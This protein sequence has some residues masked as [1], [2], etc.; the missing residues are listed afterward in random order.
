VTGELAPWRDFC[1]SFSRVAPKVLRVSSQN[2]NAVGL[3]DAIKAAAKQYMQE[4]RPFIARDGFEGYLSQ[5]DEHFKKL[6]E[7]AEGMNAAK[8]YQ[9]RITAIRKALPKINSRLEMEFADG[10]SS[11]H[12]LVEKQILTTLS[13]LVP[14][15]GLSYDQAI[16]DL[17]DNS[18]VSY[19]GTAADLREVLREVLDHLAPDADVSG[20][21]GFKLEKDRTKPT[22]K[23]KVRFILKARGV[24]GSSTELSEKATEAVD[25]IVGGL[26]RSVYNFGS[27]V[28]HVA[29]ERQSVIQL[30]RYVEAVLSD[31]LEV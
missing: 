18:R 14:T 13:S 19:R 24:S 28:T 10:G 25:A 29:G 15:A 12:S 31:L 1:A 23:Q 4:A 11:K 17:A 8:S 2:V 5:L 27:V 7:L 20:A 21:D 26:A 16:Q 30:K 6:Y 9:W 3:R 22:M